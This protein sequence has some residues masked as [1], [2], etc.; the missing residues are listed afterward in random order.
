MDNPTFFFANTV[1]R[2]CKLNLTLHLKGDSI[3]FFFSVIFGPAKINQV[4]TA[5]KIVLEN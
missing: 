5:D 4:L 1:G 2:I 3:I